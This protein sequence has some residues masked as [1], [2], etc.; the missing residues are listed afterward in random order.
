MSGADLALAQ[1]LKAGD[2]EAFRGLVRA[3]HNRRLLYT[4][5]AA[6]ELTR[7]IQWGVLD[8]RKIK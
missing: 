1:K 7:G 3:Q 2:A 4:S 6:D 5:D 8:W